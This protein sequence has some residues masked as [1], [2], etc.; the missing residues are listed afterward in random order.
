MAPS[1]RR[2]FN[3]ANVERYRAAAD[4]AGIAELGVAEHI[5]RF[6][7]S[8]AVWDHPY[9]REQAVDD[10]D[11]Y[12]AFVREE[13]DL[14]LGLEV[15][16]VPGREDITQ[17]LIE[18]CELRLR[19]RVGALPRGPRRRLRP[20]R[21]LGR[22]AHGRDTV[23]GTTSRGSAARAHRAVR[24]SS[25][26]RISSSTGARCDRCPGDLRRYYE[27]ALDGIAESLIAVEVSTAGLRKPVGELY[28][29]P[30]LPGDGVVAGCPVALSSD[31][32]VPEQVGFGYE[33]RASMLAEAR[34]ARAGGVRA[35]RAAA[36]AA[37][38]LN[39]ADMGGASAT[40]P[41]S[42][43]TAT[44]SRRSRRS[45]S[46]AF[47]LSIPTGC[48]STAIPTPTCSPTP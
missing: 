11:A 34:R 30:R 27:L 39:D 31:A 2:F 45:C 36:G 21:H 4:A 10:I 7:Q 29:A 42:T 47:T 41:A 23:W 18:R 35:A 38:Q 16:F 19:R 37:G 17:N 1:P 8:L 5:H 15:D 28:P 22:R 44:A 25:P 9:W 3:A 20:L 12:C 32:H 14:R 26:I 13:T 33:R 48:G 6:Q 24:H 40:E 43:T 46:A